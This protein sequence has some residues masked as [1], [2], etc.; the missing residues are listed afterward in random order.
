MFDSWRALSRSLYGRWTFGPRSGKRRISASFGCGADP[1][2]QRLVLSAVVTEGPV[3]T[4]PGNLT[5]NS[6]F[7]FDT[8][9][10][11]NTI[12]VGSFVPNFSFGG[13]DTNDPGGVYVYD[14]DTGALRLTLP[15]MGLSVSYK[16]GARVAIS[17]N[18]IAVGDDEEDLA[19]GHVYLF[20]ATTGDLLRTFENPAGQNY[21]DFGMFGFDVAI[22]GNL[23]A[24]GNPFTKHTPNFFEG[25]AYVFD[26][27]T[28]EL[29]HTLSNPNPVEFDGFGENVAIDGNEVAI[30][31]LGFQLGHPYDGQVY[32]FDAVTGAL[33]TTVAKPAAAFETA[34]GFSLDISGTT[35]A[36]GAPVGAPFT[37]GGKVYLFDAITG[38]LHFTLASP[39]S[40]PG[41]TK[42]RDGDT[43]ESRSV[44]RGISGDQF[45]YEVA[46][47]ENALLVGVITNTNTE[48]VE[49]FDVHTGTLVSTL[50]QPDVEQGRAG[51]GYTSL[52][53]SGLVGVIA[54]AGSSPDYA[55]PQVYI[56]QIDVND[57]P[58]VSS[59]GVEPTF[60]KKGAKQ[61][62][63]TFVIPTGL[64][65]DPD[66]LRKF[67]V[68]GGTLTVSMDAVAIVGK[69][70]TKFFDT[71][72]GLENYSGLGTSSGP[73]FANGQFSLTVQ[74]D[75]A[76]EVGDIQNFLRG[77]TFT[78]K[79]RGA[80]Q[81]ARLLRVQLTDA[82]GETSDLLRHTLH[83]RKK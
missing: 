18:V 69:K 19:S 66:E 29:L 70:K 36:V 13:P 27:S 17:G 38:E 46:I 81:E 12:V 48:H 51:F 76:T 55:D 61:R 74:L 23:L 79:G 80:R 78:T 68:G 7:G 64:V 62:G 45:G 57:P 9:V 44:P 40:T 25:E 26:V 21:P 42:Q 8:A 5:D 47:E 65:S 53:M 32:V 77:V 4:S 34:F 24:V 15:P 35:V 67:K 1:L 54:D 16:F 75:A 14:A 50:N 52:S 22:S 37:E 83:V 30:A 3:L 63:P 49:I 56:Y 33:T 20:D 58:V 11:G 31:S 39:T 6:R 60:V 72:G 43:P 2:E 59:A 10:D 71:I 82:D 41:T 28:G 73:T